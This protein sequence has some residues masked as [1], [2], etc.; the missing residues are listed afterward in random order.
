MLMLSRRL[1]TAC[2]GIGVTTTVPAGVG[3]GDGRLTMRG[4]VT[5]PV[6]GAAG[7]AAVTGGLIGD[8]ITVIIPAG[9]EAIGHAIRIRTDARQEEA[10]M[11][12]VQ[13][14]VAT[15]PVQRVGK[16]RR[17]VRPILLLMAGTDKV[18]QGELSVP[19][20]WAN[21][22][23]RPHARML[24]HHVAARIP[25]RAVPAAVLRTKEPVAARLRRRE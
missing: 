13:R 2:G 11:A 22:T 24:L 17:S 5:I 21:V 12:A 10:A 19:V 9:A 4:A 7:M 3:A 25:V 8:I 20:P 14:C 1:P 23:E 6:T 18:R 15:V 16:E